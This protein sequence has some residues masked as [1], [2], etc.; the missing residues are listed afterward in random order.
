MSLLVLLMALFSADFTLDA[1]WSD[2]KR[3]AITINATGEEETLAQ[4]LRGGSEVRYRFSS[5]L[6]RRRLLW[7]D[8][9]GDERVE[10]RSGEFDPVADSFKVTSDTHHDSFPPESKSFKSEQE[11]IKALT[12]VREIK[13]KDFVEGDEPLNIARSYISFRVEAEC[14]GMRRSVLTELPS[15]ITFGLLPKTGT[16]DSGWK[17]FGIATDI[18]PS[19][20]Q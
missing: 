14:R 13:I 4:C 3:D 10:V 19:A 8:G 5:R 2:V 18:E 1:R 11:A 12:S 20:K 7:V 15:Y 16:Y 9:C 6:C 17:S